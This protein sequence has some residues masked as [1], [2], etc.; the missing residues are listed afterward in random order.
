MK[1]TS[2][3][4]DPSSDKQRKVE[5]EG[6]YTAT[7]RYNEHVKEH[8]QTANV[9]SEAK[10]AREALEGEEREELEEAEARGKAA[11]KNAS[12]A[13][14]NGAKRQESNGE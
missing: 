13:G 9:E 7:R 5:G 14:S 2:Q 4:K 3:P 11:G 8:L 12:R 1:H 10:A 6:S